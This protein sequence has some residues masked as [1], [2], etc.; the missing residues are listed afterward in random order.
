MD[1]RRMPIRINLSFH[2]EEKMKAKEY[3][4]RYK[5]NPTDLELVRIARD[6]ILEIKTLMEQRHAKYDSA[7]FPIIDE[8]N[9]KWRAFVRISDQGFLEDGFKN[10]LGHEL[11]E[12]CQAWLDYKKQP[13]RFFARGRVNS[14][15]N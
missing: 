13:Y 7:L 10:Y 11:P 5:A 14:R 3:A 6:M 15:T 9:D 8:I 12:V 2:A 4:D 1:G